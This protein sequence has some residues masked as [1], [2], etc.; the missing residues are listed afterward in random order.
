[1]P[2][3][4]Y[5]TFD[6][7]VADYIKKGKSKS[8]A[9]RICGEIEKRSKGESLT[10]TN[11][12][13]LVKPNSKDWRHIEF[14]VPINESIVSGNDFII[15]GIAINETTTRN[16]VT[17]TAEELLKSALTLRDKPILE[18]HKNEIRKIV[19]R[20]TNNVNFDL[21]NK[22][23]PFEARIMDKGIQ[24]MIKDG[25]IKSVSV[26]AFVNNIESSS[27]DGESDKM[28][29]KGI[30]FVELSLVAV[31]ADPNAGFTMALAESF[32]LKNKVD[33]DEDDADVDEDL[34]LEE[35]KMNVE[36]KLHCPECDK[37][38]KDKK[39]LKKHMMDKHKDVEE[40]KLKSLSNRL[41]QI[42]SKVNDLITRR[43]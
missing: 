15:R 13:K 35:E 24:E 6:A 14:V 41:A 1:M 25:R 12:R 33:D 21:I 7:C 2:L 4:K 23:V 20:T 38:M 8:S 17:Y 43:K 11:V 42:E 3:G 10:K 39:E 22:N 19:G 27:A 16:G 34:D 26:G 18:D 32:R 5:S 31:P 9:N 29:A 36:E 30:D 28:V 40:E 37:E